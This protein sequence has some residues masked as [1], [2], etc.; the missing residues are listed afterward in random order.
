[1]ECLN[2]C[3]QNPHP[4]LVGVEVYRGKDYMICFCDFSGGIPDDL[5]VT[6]YS[7]AAYQLYEYEGVGSIETSDGYSNAVCYSYDVSI[8]FHFHVLDLF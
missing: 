4:D 8:H 7:P 3:S 1:M 2:W 5:N 6:D